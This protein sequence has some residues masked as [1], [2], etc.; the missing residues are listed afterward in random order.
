MVE[1]KGGPHGPAVAATGTGTDAP[2]LFRGR[3]GP[4]LPDREGLEDRVEEAA[5]GIVRWIVASTEPGRDDRL[6]PAHPRMMST[7]PVGLAYGATGVALALR[8]TAGEVPGDAVEWI[9]GRE[10]GVDSHPPGLFLGLAG[11][12]FALERLGFRGR[13]VA[14]LRE[15]YRSPLL[16]ADPGLVYGVAGWGL[17]SLHVHH[18]TGD[19]D[20]LD[21]AVEAG[22]HLLESAREDE[23]GL[24][25]V[26]APDDR[27]HYGLG[28]GAS[29]V[30]LFLLELGGATGREAFVEG[31][32][33]ALEFDLAHR[34]EKET[35]WEWPRYADDTVVEPYW[36]HGSAG[37]GAALVRFARRLGDERYWRLAEI[38]AESV[39]V[40]LTL[41]PGQWEGMSGIGEF[42]VDMYVATGEERYRDAALDLA[43]T[44]LWY[45][46]E[47]DDGLRFPGRS[48]DRVSADY[49]S[50]SAGIGL[51]FRRLL[52][53]GPRLF[54][55]MATVGSTAP[56]PRPRVALPRDGNGGA[57]PAG[58]DVPVKA[59]ATHRRHE[60][61]V[62]DESGGRG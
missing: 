44:I 51:F 10:L 25:W 48:L 3:P 27:V 31:A 49:A 59:T 1:L 53:P 56:A 11:V 2:P 60:P 7:N 24:C 34:E 22:R 46:V 40:K 21:R 6:W 33:G 42:L 32:R 16:F 37:V 12:A 61:Q 29:G 36:L 54:E 5:E 15:A 14:T 58:G 35:G 28:H 45:G 38:V 30:G 43:A 8:I 50:G 55:D 9:R 13:A 52:D 47:G 23:D 20:F 39:F 41:V 57:G 26:H 18:A 4:A 19:Q 62:T 17:V